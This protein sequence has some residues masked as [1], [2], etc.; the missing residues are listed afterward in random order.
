MDK[1]TSKQ[2]VFRELTLFALG[3]LLVLALV[4]VG[5]F[6]A[7]HWAWS[8]LAGAAVGAILASIN[9]ALIAVGVFRAVDKAE[10]GDIAAG[11]RAM[12][13]SMIGRY[14]LMIGVLVVGAKSG[15]CN[16]IAMV[17]PLAMTRPLL[18]AAELFRGKD[19][20]PKL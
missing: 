2:Q 20:D 8:V 4:C 9:Y 16:V 19:R 12:T 6:L 11:R 10:Q 7:G 13:A 14:L 5:F 1:Q 15:F 18:F 3:Q 17:I